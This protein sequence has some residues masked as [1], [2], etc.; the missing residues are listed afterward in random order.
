MHGESLD[1][2]DN[3]YYIST[4]LRLLTNRNGILSPTIQPLG[5]GKVL[6]T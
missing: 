5:A 4:T 3:I 6:C 1:V 2:T